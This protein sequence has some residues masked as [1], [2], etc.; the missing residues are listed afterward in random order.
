MAVAVAASVAGGR[1]VAG[2]ARRIALAV[3]HAEE[4]TG[5]QFAVFL[6]PAGDDVRAHA[7]SLFLEAAPDVLL[8]VA[9]DQRRVEIVTSA[10][11]RDRVPDAA[12]DDALAAMRPLLRTGAYDWALVAALDHLSIVAGPGMAPSG[13]VE[14]PDVIDER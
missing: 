13:S 10:S 14:L 9:P 5:L 6:G 7:Q 4:R 1:A 11:A 8:V 12:C 3:H 2:S